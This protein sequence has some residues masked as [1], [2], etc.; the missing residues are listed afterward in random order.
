MERFEQAEAIADRI[1]LP[2]YQARALTTLAENLFRSKLT[3]RGQSV[4]DR[5]LAITQLDADEL[6]HRHFKKCPLA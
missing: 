4:L 6:L 1:E 5:A 2:A 3:R